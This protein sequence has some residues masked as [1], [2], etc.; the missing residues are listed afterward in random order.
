M[1]LV[2]DNHRRRRSGQEWRPGEAQRQFSFLGPLRPR[3]LLC[4][5][6]LAT[7]I[8]LLPAHAAGVKALLWWRAR[9]PFL[10]AS[11]PDATKAL[12][13]SMGFGRKR[14]PVLWAAA[15]AFPGLRPE[16]RSIT[17]MSSTRPGI[18]PSTFPRGNASRRAGLALCVLWLF[19]ATAQS[20][21]SP[22][23]AD[24][25][26]HSP[27]AFWD[28]DGATADFDGDG[29]PDLLLITQAG[30]GARGVHYRLDFQLSG[31]AH[32]SSISV[33]GEAGGLHVVPRD[34][35]AD[36]D[37]D[38]VVTSAWTFAPLGVW[39]NDGHGNFTGGNPAAYPDAIWTA[40]S[41]LRD[42]NQLPADFTALVRTLRRSFNLSIQRY[43]VDPQIRS[44]RF[45]SEPSLLAIAKAASP[46]RSRSPP[47]RPA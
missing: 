13:F 5:A 16:F 17:T 46:S 37:L 7:G 25:Q 20:A 21:Q 31:N 36:G 45:L 29:R 30:R 12:L 41:T 10:T 9:T 40:R 39:I 43:L 47:S 23:P 32:P 22:P 27:H 8:L 42:K 15:T 44:G 11:R 38:L 6:W 3:T 4:I 35:D 24:W 28:Q 14:Y 19:S 34:V 26:L 2:P 33:F 1:A 18:R